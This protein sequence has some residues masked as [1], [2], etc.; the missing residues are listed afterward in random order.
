MGVF[1]VKRRIISLVF[2]L[3]FVFSLAS[4]A[5][6]SG[7]RNGPD[8]AGE[9][10]IYITEND[11]AWQEAI[12]NFEK[13]YGDVA[14]RVETFQTAAEL[15][16]RQND[17]M[18]EGGGPDLI[19]YSAMTADS[20]DLR[21]MAKSGM[22]L[23]LD[24]LFEQDRDF[25]PDN[26]YAPVLDNGFFDDARY[27]VTVGFSLPGFVTTEERLEE[28]DI[29]LD[30]DLPMRELFAKIAG[31]AERLAGDPENFAYLWFW[32]SV[33]FTYYLGCS[34]LLTPDD[35]GNLFSLDRMQKMEEFFD[36][37]RSMYQE[38]ARATAHASDTQA[39]L[40]RRGTFVD[41]GL[42]PAASLLYAATLYE[43]DMGR[44]ARILMVPAYDDADSY[45][46]R[47][48]LE[49]AVNRNTKV[50]ELAYRFLRSVM[51]GPTLH[52]AKV[53][54][55][56]P[57]P[58]FYSPNRRI[59]ESYLDAVPG[60][61][62]YKAPGIRA[63]EK[64]KPAVVNALSQLSGCFSLYPE[65]WDVLAESIPPYLNGEADF[66]TCYAD[67]TGRLEQYLAD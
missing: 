44:T 59:M 12:E 37:Y 50:P 67:L 62:S 19:L 53:P 11:T 51:D 24:R 64:V 21:R 38:R 34:G 40:L 41:T 1:C 27:A 32:D 30:G 60:L 36:L 6:R 65:L 25:N 46:A 29:V 63:Y 48:L 2:L 10:T 16:Q 9:L 39:E 17:E 47:S 49:I 56:S 8:K 43:R 13:Q 20:L 35:P 18:A 7:G 42:D 31:E 15:E 28:A 3:V 57:G 23:S 58:C 5:A 14:V 66:D 45:L 22:L 52:V 4:C 33:S 61:G 54:D 55:G 26:Y